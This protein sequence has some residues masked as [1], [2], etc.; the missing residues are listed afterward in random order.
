MGHERAET[1]LRLLAEAELR[2]VGDRDRGPDHR[3]Y[4]HALAPDGSSSDLE[5]TG[6]GPHHLPYDQLW[7]VDDEGTRY[8]ARFEIGQGETAA[9]RG[10]IQL[11]PV[12]R[13]APGGWT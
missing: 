13:A 5:I 1:Y 2:R 12:P 8:T 10:V 6:A 7:A 11:S 9:W 3:R 4:A